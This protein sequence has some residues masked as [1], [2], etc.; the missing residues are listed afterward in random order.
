M[1]FLFDDTPATPESLR[2][3]SLNR[4]VGFYVDDIEEIKKVSPYQPFSLNKVPI[5]NIQQLIPKEVSEI[6]YLYN[7]MFVQD[8]GLRRYTFDPI[9][10]GWQENKR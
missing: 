4:Y 6:A 9:L 8:I 1:K 7:N 5:E 2:K 10:G 3:W